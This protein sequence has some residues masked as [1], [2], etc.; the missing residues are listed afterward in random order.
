VSLI[1]CPPIIYRSTIKT[2]SLL[3][4]I[5][6]AHNIL[7]TSATKGGVER[8]NYHIASKLLIHPTSKL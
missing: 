6:L 2:V 7:I 4:T 1:L 3:R 5:Y 8:G